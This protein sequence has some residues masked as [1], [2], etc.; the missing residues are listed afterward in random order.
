MTFSKALVLTLLTALLVSAC[1]DENEPPKENEPPEKKKTTYLLFGAAQNNGLI[2][3]YDFTSQKLK[4]GSYGAQPTTSGSG[5][6][7]DVVIDG[8]YAYCINTQGNILSKVNVEEFILEKSKIAS[9]DPRDTR[10]DMIHHYDNKIFWTGDANS[11]SKD[12]F[13][14]FVKTYDK[15]LNLLDSIGIPNILV[16]FDV[17]IK[18]DIIFM[19]VNKEGKRSILALDVNTKQLKKEFET[20][21]CDLVDADGYEI[22]AVGNGTVSILNTMDLSLANP[23]LQSSPPVACNYESTEN[24]VFGRARTLFYFV[25]NPQPATFPYSLQAYDF[26][27]EAVINIGGDTFY[28][29]HA[30]IV[31]DEENEVLVAFAKNKLIILDR[32]GKKVSEFNVP[33]EVVTHISIQYE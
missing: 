33:A 27:T 22:F 8:K 17:I 32:D 3:S 19:C 15:E 23:T 29:I 30:P 25:T 1:D 4:P 9:I 5:H 10:R 12:T 24:A 16:A 2:F 7:R 14:W 13:G 11:L 28:Q 26:S 21:A 31:Y 6:F 20:T 18:N